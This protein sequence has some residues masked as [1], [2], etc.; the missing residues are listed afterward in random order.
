MGLNLNDLQNNFQTNP[1]LI[2]TETIANEMKKTQQILNDV[3]R[4]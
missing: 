4:S 2:H 3:S 1:S